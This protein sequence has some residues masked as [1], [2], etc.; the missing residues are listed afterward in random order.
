NNPTGTAGAGTCKNP[1]CSINMCGGELQC[2]NGVPTCTQVSGSDD[3]CDGID[4]DCDGVPDDDW[5][6]A[7]PDGPD[8]V[9][10]NADDCPCT[11]G[12]MG[13]APESCENGA[14]I[15]QGSPTGPESCN[16]ADDDCNGQVDEGT[17]GDGTEGPPGSHCKACQCA[18]PCQDGEFPCPLG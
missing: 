15:C 4:Q 13:N 9:L 16:C 8:N 10:G 18:F 6:C 2:V 11:G 5:H 12:G 7:D 3:N 17:C 14:R 1:D